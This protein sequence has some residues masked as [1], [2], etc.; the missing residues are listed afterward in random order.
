MMKNWNLL[1]TA[2]E[3]VITAMT[4]LISAGS[5][6]AKLLDDVS[7]SYCDKKSLEVQKDVDDWM[8]EN[9]IELPKAQPSN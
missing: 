1:S 9:S 7:K 4:D 2:I 3:Q 6:H 5:R 8:K